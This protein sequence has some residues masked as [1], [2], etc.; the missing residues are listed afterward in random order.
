MYFGPMVCFIPVYLK[1]HRKKP[2]KLKFLSNI[3]QKCLPVENKSQ[4]KA[5]GSSETPK[6]DRRNLPFLT[7]LHVL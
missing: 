3:R 6:C 2:N 5:F 4:S 1:T 7:M